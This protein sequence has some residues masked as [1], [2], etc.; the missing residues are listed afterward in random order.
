MNN[1]KGWIKLERELLE[2]QWSGNPQMV[3]L[4][5]RLRL[6]AA[7]GE[8]QQM[9]QWLAPGQIATTY[10]QLAQATGLSLRTL[11]TCLR[12]LQDEGRV[13]LATSHRLT[14][15]TLPDLLEIAAPEAPE[16]RHSIDTVATHQTPRHIGVSEQSGTGAEQKA[17]HL[18]YKKKK[19][20]EITPTPRAR[21]SFSETKAA[22]PEASSALSVK[23]ASQSALGP[24]EAPGPADGPGGPRT[25]TADEAANTLQG[26]LDNPVALNF[27]LLRSG[28]EYEA[29]IRHL[30][31]FDMQCQL[32]GK[33]WRD[34]GDL[35][36]HYGNWL[37]K[38]RSYQERQER[39]V[40]ERELRR[41]EERKM[42]EQTR[43]HIV[44][45]MMH[46]EP[47]PVDPNTL[48][49]WLKGVL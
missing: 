9:G 11:R 27:L 24:A 13:E 39:R 42:H 41:Q 3:A 25:V 32:N 19:E 34:E 15:V 10:R 23:A 7:Y 44:R 14:I 1:T 35:L 31:E 48:P 47:P 5:V 8:T 46:L 21:E 43:T 28:M 22:E 12:R 2:W 26:L 45:Q 17:T 49:D 33:S 20:E 6:S 36:S 18:L 29:V 38:K 40:S 37:A 16:S 4:Y 30:T